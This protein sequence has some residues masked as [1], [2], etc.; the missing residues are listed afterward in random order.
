[1]KTLHLAPGMSAG[2]SLIQAV[3]LA[4]L[5]DE[6]LRFQDDLGCGPIEPYTPAARAA[7]WSEVY[8]DFDVA[9]EEAALAGF[10]E[11]VATTDARVVVWFGR[12]SASE[13][14]FF[15]ACADRLGDR[16]YDIMDVQLPMVRPEGGGDRYPGRHMAAVIEEDLRTLF[17]T[18]RPITTA[19]REDA[20]RQWRKLQGENAPFRVVTEDGLVSAPIDFFDEWILNEAAAEEWRSAARIIGN[21][22]GYHGDP[23]RQTGDM[24]LRVR[25]VALVDEGKLVA[26]GDP[27]ERSAPIRLPGGSLP[28]PPQLLTDEIRQRFEAL[29]QGKPPMRRWTANPLTRLAAGDIIHATRFGPSS[30]I[31]LVVSVEGG[32]IRTRSIAQQQVIDFDIE[33]GVGAW[34]DELFGDE[35]IECR[36]D[37]IEPLPLEVYNALL[38]QDRWHR[39][40]RDP[41]RWREN[42]AR[43]RAWSTAE[44]FFRQ[45]KL[46]A[47]DGA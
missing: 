42:E 40:V 27:W 8:S 3:R 28:P 47:A 24:M 9:K 45:H 22:L 12:N 5:D 16:P 1:M 13:L 33:T 37:S 46:P 31:C 10:W 36:I 11:R 30:I 39:L 44:A 7:W 17:G 2:G 29:W 25:L 14:A 6:V 19:E 4:G 15:L 26:H 32:F 34:H 35:P 20:R 38:E 21:V 23:Y 41:K 43:R 18:E